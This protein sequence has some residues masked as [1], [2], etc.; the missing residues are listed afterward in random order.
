MN[1]VVR[2]LVWNIPLMCCAIACGSGSDT[3]TGN[4]AGAGPQGAAGSSSAGVPSMAAGGLGNAGQA[5]VGSGSA[6]L[7]GAGAGSGGG[8]AGAAGLSGNA[9]SLGGGGTGGSSGGAGG[10]GAGGTGGSASS[11]CV[12]GGKGVHYVDSAAGNDA[13][14]GTT[15]ASAWKT[16]TAVNGAT[17]QPGDALCFH[18]GGS[19]TGQLAPKGSGSAAAPIVI[20]QYGVGNK[21]R[22][23]A[24]SGNLQAL[25][26][27]NV[28]YWEVN[29]LELTNKQTSPGDFRGISVR[30]KDTGVLNHIYVR[31]CFVHDVTGVVNWI[32]GSSAD[33][34]AP[35]VTF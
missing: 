1:T 30:G 14:D 26:L 28:Q 16:L 20:D 5:G 23:A 32:G 21:P 27:Q 8:S 12:T 34:E 7:G 9:G 11:L 31:G 22:I 6:G 3:A 2:R 4:T 19:W 10:A 35:W 15:I 33:N 17:Y 13:A 29:N 25:L 18:A 24:G